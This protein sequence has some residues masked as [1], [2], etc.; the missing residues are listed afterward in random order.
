MRASLPALL[1]LAALLL[2]PSGALAARASAPAPPAMA[3]HAGDAITTAIPTLPAGAREFEL[4]LLPEGG[5]EIQLSAELAAG[6]R[7][8]TWRMPRTYATRARL[9]LR[10]GDARDEWRSE[11]SA[12][13][14]LA[15]LS[16]NEWLRLACGGAETRAWKECGGASAAALAGDARRDEL[17]PGD[18]AL[19]AAPSPPSPD[20]DT[21]ACERVAFERDADAPEAR[22][23]APTFQRTP[24][25]RPLLI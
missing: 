24:A 21:P 7:E 2:G 10:S 11:P 1:A 4:V 12:E 25:F 19:Q 18:A 14:T 8:V 13:F 20:L 9:V 22:V 3:V 16:P 15:A 23:F 6:V 17:S 5:P